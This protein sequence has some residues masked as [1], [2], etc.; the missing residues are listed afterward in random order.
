MS[1]LREIRLFGDLGKKYG[2]YFKLAISTPEEAVRALSSQLKG[3]EKFIIDSEKNGVGYVFRVNDSEIADRKELYVEGVSPIY[4]VPV[5]SGSSGETRVLIGAALIAGSFLF[6]QTG[7]AARYLF[8]SGIAFSAGGAAEILTR[9]SLPSL[10][11]LEPNTSESTTPSY[12]FN[13]PVNT[14]AQGHPVPVCYGR[15][16]VGGAVI[17]A[18]IRTESIMAGYIYADVEM[19]VEA[20]SVEK[21][22][23]IL[24]PKPPASWHKKEQVSFTPKDPNV[25]PNDYWGNY[26]NHDRWVFRYFYYKKI[27]LPRY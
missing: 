13:G 12:S 11:P 26:I 5:I 8:S 2:Q 27:L 6:D 18:S 4:I 1:I 10:Q 19:S 24:E 21:E 16:L 22:T 25:N 23:N 9:G 17:S 3:F 14:V 15:M 7:T 20:T